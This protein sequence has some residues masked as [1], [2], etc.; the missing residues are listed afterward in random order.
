MNQLYLYFLGWFDLTCISSFVKSMRESKLR[1]KGNKN[2]AKTPSC[3]VTFS[4]TREADDPVR[5]EVL[6]FL[7]FTRLDIAMRAP[8]AVGSSSLGNLF[9]SA[10]QSRSRDD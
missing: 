7:S 10:F 1:T 8:L 9:F 2:T 6:E 4:S 3:D 5:K